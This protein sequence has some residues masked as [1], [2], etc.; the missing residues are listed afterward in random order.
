M[1]VCV[2]VCVCVYEID[3]Q[4]DRLRERQRPR[5]SFSVLHIVDC[6]L[7]RDESILKGWRDDAKK[8]QARKQFQTLTKGT[9][10]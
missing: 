3:R 2:C 9:K 4:T 8:L 1:C 10:G 7:F 5:D 6:F